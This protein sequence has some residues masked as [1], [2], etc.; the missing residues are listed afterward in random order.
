MLKETFGPPSNKTNGIEPNFSILML[1]YT[2]LVG[3]CTSLFLAGIYVYGFLTYNG[4]THIFSYP[5]ERAWIPFTESVS[6]AIVILGCIYWLNKGKLKTSIRVFLIILQI[7]VYMTPIVVGA[8]F[9]DPVLDLIYFA[10]VLAAMFLDRWELIVIMLV[11]MVMLTFYYFG[12]N[13]GWFWSVFDPP[14]IDRLF[15]NYTSIAVVTTVLMIT[16][17]QVLNQSAN[18]VK[19]NQ[20]L[21]TY[22]NS[23]EDMVENR[24]LQLNQE[25]ERAEKANQAK[26]EFLAN[27]SHELRTPLNAIIGYS[28]MVEEELSLVDTDGSK[29]LL[30][31]VGRIEYSGRHLLDLINN[32]LDISKIEARQMTLDTGPVHLDTL[33]EEVVITTE[34]LVEL[35]TNNFR[36]ENKLTHFEM[37]S[38]GQKIKQIL[39]NLL[40][41]AFK[42]TSDAEILLQIESNDLDGIEMIDF[43][44]EDQGSGIDPEFVDKLFEPFLQGDNSS[45]RLHQGTGLG[46][47]ISKQFSMMLRGDILVESA[48]GRGSKF[49]LRVPRYLDA[50]ETLP[51]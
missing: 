42:F 34:P 9:Y 44:V 8:G 32:L 47:A 43:C 6:I 29:D 28:E 33:I 37:I 35:N 30:D 22:Q 36:I 10:L 31:D 20:Q 27:M 4:G 41:N 40:S 11:Y 49:T 14:S 48:I 2:Y 19:L 16:V 50:G 7:V 39:I 51:A 21:Q 18:L 26:S 25:R 1:Y 45:T 13:L 12:Q 3:F 24:T 15:V 5:A 23:L 46:L 17:R 38:D